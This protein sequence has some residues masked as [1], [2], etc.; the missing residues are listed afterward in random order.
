M[1]ATQL[2]NNA[3]VTSAVGTASQSQVQTFVGTA[4]SGTWKARLGEIHPAVRYVETGALAALITTANLQTALRA[5]KP[6][7]VDAIGTDLTLGGAGPLGSGAITA[8]WSGKYGALDM[9]VFECISIDLAGGT[10]SC[11]E[12]TALVVGSFDDDDLDTLASMRARLTAID[13]TTFSAAKLNKM[14]YNDIMYA[15]R[16]LD[17]PWTV[18]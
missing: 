8:T 4:A 2:G 6:N 17:E 7:G 10:V 5:L 16:L 3:G 13:G 14:T 15:V 1:T 9:P 11:T 18:K 12:T